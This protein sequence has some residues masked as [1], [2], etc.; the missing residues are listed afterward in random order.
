MKAFRRGR[1]RDPVLSD[2][3]VGLLAFCVVALLVGVAAY[4]YIAPANRQSLTFAT[5][6]AVSLRGGEDVRLAGVSVGNV[7]GLELGDHEVTV[8][9]Q[10]DS[11]V[12]IGDQTRIE[13]RLLTAVGGYFVTLL[14]QGKPIEL[15]TE[16][17]LERVTVPYTI[18]DTLQEL[19]RITDDVSGVP[20][21]KIL[22]QLDSGLD[23][24]PKAIRNAVSGLQTIAGIIS[25]QKGQLQSTLNLVSEYSSALDGSR[26]YLF[27]LARKT[28]TV[29]SEYYTY[30]H[31]FS[32]AIEELGNVLV[33]L[34][35]VTRLYVSHEDEFNRAIDSARAGA[36]QAKDGIDELIDGLEPL[37]KHLNQLVRT[38]KAAES[39]THQSPDALTIGDICLPIAGRKC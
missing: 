26:D 1:G 7:D 31:R 32:L 20:V 29:L 5:K 13:V 9:L 2:L 25:R 4:F 12:K 37:S 33:R 11:D 39:G 15:P 36:Q 3:T 30:R 23:G 14:P 8:R 24:N 6:D 28:N 10:I 17:P 18:A 16:I 19:P 34:G 38:S 22:D 35:A 21:D 27:S